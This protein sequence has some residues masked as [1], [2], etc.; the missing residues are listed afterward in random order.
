M[1]VYFL[2]LVSCFLVPFRE[3]LGSC[4]LFARQLRKRSGGF[5]YRSIAMGGRAG[6]SGRKPHL[7][8]DGSRKHKKRERSVPRDEGQTTRKTQGR[9]VPQPASVAGASEHASDIATCLVN[10]AVQQSNDARIENERVDAEFE[11]DEDGNPRMVERLTMPPTV[12]AQV[13]RVKDNIKAASPPLPVP[14]LNLLL[15]PHSP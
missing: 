11:E 13:E 15:L 2:G 10:T 8:E 7:N 4:S 1:L 5:N 14:T 6:R 3:L 12:R 9:A